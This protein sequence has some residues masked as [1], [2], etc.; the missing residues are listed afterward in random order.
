MRYTFPALTVLALTGSL[1]AG[2]AVPASAA[3]ITLESSQPTVVVGERGRGVWTTFTARG[4][5]ASVRAMDLE[6]TGPD[7][8]RT[9]IDLVRRDGSDRWTGSFSFNRFDAPGKWGGALFV[10]DEAGGEKK[11]AR[12][13]F[14]V[15]RRTTLSAVAPSGRG[16]GVNGALRRLG[17]TGGFAPYAGQK[18]RLYKWTGGAW[19]LVETTVTGGKGKYAFAKRSGRLQVR[20]AGTAVNAASVKTAP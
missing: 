16:G 3:A 12:L 7:G 8:S 17:E 10:R 9:L 4:A 19:K 11:A 15:K 13:M 6:L 20:Y 14:H 1:V 18:V 2:P 5:G